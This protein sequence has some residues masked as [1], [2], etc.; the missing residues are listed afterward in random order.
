M[1][2][3]NGNDIDD[4]FRRA[5]DKYPLRTDN[6]DW[7]RL[8]AD[9]EKD[10]SLILPPISEEGDR[11]RR[12]RFFWLFLLFPLAGVGYYMG[13]RTSQGSTAHPAIARSAQQGTPAGPAAV[14]TSSTI[15]PNS[16]SIPSG[17]ATATSG[18]EIATAGR[19]DHTAGP[20][21]AVPKGTIAGPATTNRGISGPAATNQG[22]SGATTTNR[23]VAGLRLYGDR[24]ANSGTRSFSAGNTIDAGTIAGN[25]TGT[26]GNTAGTTGNTVSLSL[27]PLGPH[28]PQLARTAGGVAVNVNVQSPKTPV[29]AT[30]TKLAKPRLS[31]HFYAG[32]VAAPDLSMVKF[33]SVKGVGTT[34]GLLLGYN[35]NSRW[36]IESGLYLDRK[37]YYSDGEYFST[38]NITI[39][40]SIKISTVD[41]ICNMWEIPINVRYNLSQG[42][43]TK[44][45]ATAGFSTYLMTKENYSYQYEYTSGGASWPYHKQ[46]NSA[47]NYLFS[48]VNLSL[49]YEQKIGKVGNLRI[50]PYL[51]VPL[52]GIGT[53]SLPIMSAGLNI[54]ITRRIW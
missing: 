44:W 22:I 54:G 31:T 41:G 17:G 24:G 28:A 46:Y 8:A 49:G 14:S 6:A 42:E 34:F 50:E 1:S 26:T 30:T 3:L 13:H 16:S 36:A 2:Q 35:I 39:P 15:N 29:P 51:R 9:L 12:K 53:G 43:K 23:G 19:A 47:S 37:K 40:P 33:Q 11:R 18:R 20:D 48:V 25:T 45:F 4:L 21:R 5:S 27:H 38:K 32:L 7:D 10:P 52:S